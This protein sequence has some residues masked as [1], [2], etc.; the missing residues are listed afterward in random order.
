MVTEEILDKLKELQ[1]I[2]AKENVVEAKK[3]EAKY[4]LPSLKELLEKT[5]REY[6]EKDAK[7]MEYKEEIAHLERELFE[8]ESAREKAEKGMDTVTTQR[9]YEALSNEIESAK[10]KEQSVRK[11][12]QILER[13]DQNLEEEIKKYKEDIDFQEKEL[14]QRIAQI[15]EEESGYDAELAELKRLEDDLSVGIDKETKANLERIIKSKDG[16]GVVAVVG[17]GAVNGYVCTGCHMILP[18]QFANNVRSGMNIQYCPYCSRIL[19]Y[20]ESASAE[21]LDFDADDAGSLADL[22]D[23]DYDMDDEF[24][25]EMDGEGMDYDE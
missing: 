23:D 12:I 14:E 10:E 11:D 16:V 5:K 24:D 1:D 13:Q 2:L 8:A 3:K 22:Y 17:V 19:Y 20:D 21:E 18:A 9:E 4:I 6:L 15:S 7:H 25:E